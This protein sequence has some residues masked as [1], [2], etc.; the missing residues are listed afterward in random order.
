MGVQDRQRDAVVPEGNRV[1]VDITY[2][3]RYK[4]PA[5]AKAAIVT[6]TLIADRFVQVFPVYVGGAVLE[7]RAEIALERTN[8]P[9]SSTGCTR[10]LDDVSLALGPTGANKNGALNNL[11]SAGRRRSRATASS[12]ARRSATSRPPSRP[13][14]TT[15]ARS[16]TRSDLSRSPTRSP[17]TTSSST[18]SSATSLGLHPARGG[19][20]RAEQGAGSAGPGGRHGA[21]LREGQPGPGREGRR[22]AGRRRRVVDKQKDSL[23][24]V[25][26]LVPWGW[27]TSPWRTTVKS[28]TFGARLSRARRGQPRQRAVRRRGELRT[29]R[30]RS[31]PASC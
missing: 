4:L 30:T 24:T 1:R 12:A 15:A 28:G 2:D 16:S 29:C 23:N 3:S 26:R 14:A 31:S 7:D 9:S 21:R 17:P 18:A 5:D 11:L 6:P 27:A 19:A 10:A 8:T 22:A 20:G 13:S 25:A